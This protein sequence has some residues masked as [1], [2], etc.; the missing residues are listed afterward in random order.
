MQYA[1]IV[2][3]RQCNVFGAR[4]RPWSAPN[5]YGDIATVN[6]A[7]HSHWGGI[8]AESLG[9]TSVRFPCRR[10]LVRQIN[11]EIIC[12]RIKIDGLLYR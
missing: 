3:I 12:R 2:I 7:D 4:L 11:G 6:L 5:A 1:D 10:L 8:L 9:Q